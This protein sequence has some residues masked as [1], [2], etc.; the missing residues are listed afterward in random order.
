MAWLH[1]KHLNEIIGLESKKEIKKGTPLDS[2]HYEL[3]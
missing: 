1:P 3:E 2:S